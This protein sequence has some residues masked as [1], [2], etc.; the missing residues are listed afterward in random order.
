[1]EE[2]KPRTSAKARMEWE[3]KTYKKHVIRLRLKEDKDLIDACVADFKNKI[4]KIEDIIYEQKQ[5]FP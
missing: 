2:N 1:M 3:N 4:E 5:R